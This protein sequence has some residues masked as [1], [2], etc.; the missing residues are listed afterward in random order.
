VVFIKNSIETPRLI[1]GAKLISCMEVENKK[2]NM[3]MMMTMEMMK[4]LKGWFY[5]HAAFGLCVA[6]WC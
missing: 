2:E 5:M 4:R 3:K 6:A 1:E